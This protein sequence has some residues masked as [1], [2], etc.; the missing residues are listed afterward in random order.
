MKH[1][2]VKSALLI[3]LLSL[4]T[5]AVGACGDTPTISPNVSVTTITSKS[6]SSTFGSGTAQVVHLSPSYV[7]WYTDLASLK[8]DAKLVVVG[9]VIKVNPSIQDTAYA[10]TTSVFNI[11][12]VLSDPQNLLKGSTTI[13]IN[14]VG[15]VVN[16]IVYKNE[17][18][19]I[20]KQSDEAILFLDVDTTGTLY[21]SIGG[22][23]GRFNINNDMVIPATTSGLKLGIGKTK[24]QFVAETKAQSLEAIPIPTATTI[25]S[26]SRIQLGQK[27]NFFQFYELAKAQSILVKAST[28]ARSKTIT[29]VDQ[30]K[31][32]ATSLNRDLAPVVKPTSSSVQ[33]PTYIIFVFANGTTIGFEYNAATATLTSNPPDNV[34]VTAPGDFVRMAGIS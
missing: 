27:V 19:P 34:M 2:L 10:R 25:P 5:V 18:E 16:N 13:L 1:K 29:D 31:M 30:I 33:P 28:V 17:D 21:Y 6:T 11:S 9:T 15:G 23:S 14:Q 26:V 12:E 3:S 20:F 32:I 4:I 7:N 8:R 24:A 22:P